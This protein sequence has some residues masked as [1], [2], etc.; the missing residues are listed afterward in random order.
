MENIISRNINYDLTRDDFIN[1]SKEMFNPMGY[2]KEKINE[3]RIK[4][5]LFHLVNIQSKKVSLDGIEAAKEAS[6]S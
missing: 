4:L 3:I 2:E 6:F 5:G 1:T